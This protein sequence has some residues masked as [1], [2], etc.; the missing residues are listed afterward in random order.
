MD[1]RSSR[2]NEDLVSEEVEV[3]T[4]GAIAV[5]RVEEAVEVDEVRVG[6]SRS[7]RVPEK[8]RLGGRRCRSMEVLSEE[9]WEV[10]SRGRKWL[11]SVLRRFRGGLS[12]RTKRKD[13]GSRVDRKEVKLLV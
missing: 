2:R 1:I 10:G 5:E 11:S 12:T 7:C 8:V 4:A 13:D 6:G 9:E 3:G